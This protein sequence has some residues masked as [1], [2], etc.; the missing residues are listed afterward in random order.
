V[1][2]ALTEIAILSAFK[3]DIIF[4]RWCRLISR[5][6]QCLRETTYRIAYEITKEAFGLM[7]DPR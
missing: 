3:L 1:L 5:I 6:V 7:A 4:K 2:P